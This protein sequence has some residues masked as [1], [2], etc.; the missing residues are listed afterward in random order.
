MIIPEWAQIAIAI[1]SLFALTAVY[2]I[3]AG[4]LGRKARASRRARKQLV[5]MS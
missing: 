5:E 1:N 3:K 4:Y 2:L